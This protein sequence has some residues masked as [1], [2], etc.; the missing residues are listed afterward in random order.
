MKLA[1]APF[2]CLRHF[3]Y[4]HGTAM[5]TQM[6]VAIANIFMAKIEIEILSKSALKPLVWK[7]Y[8]D[9]I[10]SLWNTNKEGVTKFIEQANN[11]HPTIKFTAEISETETNFLD[12]TVYK[13]ERFLAES[14]LD[15]RIHFKPT[16]TFQ[17]KH[18]STCH[19]SGVKRGFIK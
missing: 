3:L 1:R 5:G 17:Y 18:S 7:H 16:E 10:V 9:D 14:V 6:A 15:V 8:I 11:H 13:G 4:T 2:C 19:P 12:T